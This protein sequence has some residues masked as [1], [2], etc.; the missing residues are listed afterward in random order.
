MGFFK[1]GMIPKAGVTTKPETEF[2]RK[3]F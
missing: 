1:A 3:D 2:L